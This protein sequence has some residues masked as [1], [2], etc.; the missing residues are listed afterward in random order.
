MKTHKF[1]LVI[2]LALAVLIPGQQNTFAAKK[3]RHQEVI[4]YYSP[5]WAPDSRHII[6]IKK[7]TYSKLHYDWL[8]E[9]TKSTDMIT[10]R[11]FC[12]CKTDIDTK[13]EEI[14]RKFRIKEWYSASK[15]HKSGWRAA[16]INKEDKTIFG[17][18]RLQDVAVSA[19]SEISVNKKSSDILMVVK[20]NGIYLF[21][22]DSGDIRKIIECKHCVYNPRWS[23]DGKQVLYQIDK[24]VDG[25]HISELWLVNTDGTN[26]HLLVDN[27]SSGNWHPSENRITFY[28][29]SE[30]S[31]YYSL[32]NNS[33]EKAR[34]NLYGWSSDWTKRI[35]GHEIRNK[36]GKVVARLSKKMNFYTRWSPDGT[37]ILGV[38]GIGSS[39]SIGVINSD[40]TGFKLLLK[41]KSVKY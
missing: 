23:P 27:A 41:R 8:A 26:D 6:Y 32:S 16:W 9:I 35:D 10:G 39:T 14:I 37:K 28:R 3:P 34:M 13:K 24:S 12:I 20:R 22:K 17:D 7:I 15:K 2:L 25:K 29:K 19:I 38:D 1:R 5:A 4:E 33:I 31:Y 11:D 21:K 18:D 40:G 30:G 36:S